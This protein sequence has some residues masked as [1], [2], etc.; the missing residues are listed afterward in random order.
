MWYKSTKFVVVTVV[1]VLIAVVVVVVF[2]QIYTN[3]DFGSSFHGSPVNFSLYISSL[4]VLKTLYSKQRKQLD[5]V[6]KWGAIIVGADREG[7]GD[8]WGAFGHFL[9]QRKGLKMRDGS[10]EARISG[11]GLRPLS[12]QFSSSY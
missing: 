12:V 8:G 11:D 5:S 9:E 7:V 2:S 4:H 3:V 6:R 1:V 10:S